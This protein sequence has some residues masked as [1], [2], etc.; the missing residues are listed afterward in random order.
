[1]KEYCN[2]F[3]LKDL[4]GKLNLSYHLHRVVVVVER[5]SDLSNCASIIYDAAGGLRMPTVQS[6]EEEVC[7]V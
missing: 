6:T 2:I 4:L 5:N 1:M 7:G 3:F